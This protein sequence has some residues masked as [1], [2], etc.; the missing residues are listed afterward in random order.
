M[1]FGPQIIAGS[2]LGYWAQLLSIYFGMPS[3][4]LTLPWRTSSRTRA[5]NGMLVWT[6]SPTVPILWCF[7]QC[8][9][10]GLDLIVTPFTLSQS[11]LYCNLRSWGHL[12][13][14]TSHEVEHT[15]VE[16][17]KFNRF[18]IVCE[19]DVGNLRILSHHRSCTLLR[20]PL[21]RSNTDDQYLIPYG[22]QNDGLTRRYVWYQ[23]LSTLVSVFG[24]LTWGCGL[25]VACF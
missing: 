24:M 12:T 20:A 11:V 7:L 1:A 10:T 8:W 4:V 17:I 19:Q 23:L 5:L 13:L 3:M 14:K 16:Q 15:V 22:C 6:I 21:S 18:H 9:T 2:L 25:G